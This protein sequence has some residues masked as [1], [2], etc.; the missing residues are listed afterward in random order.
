MLDLCHLSK[1]GAYAL[2]PTADIGTAW[3]ALH[4][5]VL[6]FTRGR[7]KEKSERTIQQVMTQ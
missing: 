6:V 5:E 3:K 2:P 1:Q 4:Q 7:L